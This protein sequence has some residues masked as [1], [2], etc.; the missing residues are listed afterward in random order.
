MGLDEYDAWLV[1]VKN[2]L[3]KLIIETRKKQ[4]LTQAEVAKLMGATQ[5]VISRM[6][7]GSTKSITIDYL[8]KVIAV[9]GGS[10]DK[11]IK[12]SA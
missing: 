12:I 8:L 7:C 6:E 10:P 4:N 11:M 2:R 9:L 3:I 1:S 5:S